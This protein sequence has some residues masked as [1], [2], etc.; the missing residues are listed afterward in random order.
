[1]K[2]TSSNIKNAS[3]AGI[4]AYQKKEVFGPAKISCESVAFSD[5]KQN[6]LIQSESFGELEGNRINE[7]PFQTS[8]Y[9]EL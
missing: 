2:V 5:S 7:V 8:K 1:M 4:A 3:I 9:Y 6:F